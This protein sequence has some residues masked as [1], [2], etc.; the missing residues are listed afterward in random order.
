MSVLGATSPAGVRSSSGAG[1]SPGPV[2]P[3]GVITRRSAWTSTSRQWG[4]GGPLD[5]PASAHRVGRSAVH[6]GARAR[7]DVVEPSD[8]AVLEVVLVAAQHQPDAARSVQRHQL[9]DLLRH[10]LVVGPGAAGAGGGRTASATG[11][12]LRPRGPRSAKSPPARSGGSSSKQCPPSCSPQVVSTHTS[13]SRPPI[14]SSVEQ[15]RL[16][17]ASPPRDHVEPNR[18]LEVEVVGQLLPVVVGLLVRAVVV[19]GRRVHGQV[20]DEV[21]VRL[22][23]GEVPVVVLVAALLQSV[24]APAVDVVAQADDGADRV[25]WPPVRSIVRATPCWRAGLA[26]LIDARRRSRP[27]PGTSPG[28]VVVASTGGCASG[29]VAPAR[30]GRGSAALAVE[31]PLVGLPSAHAW[32]STATR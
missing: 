22:V 13:S 23:E 1:W 30:L 4:G 9:S 21:A 31:H 20:V 3:K 11:R 12:R 15:S 29:P 7:H 14:G 10:A 28:R 18:G 24:R 16:Q 5:V 32:P 19:A 6:L 17:D 27:T 25:A 8:P 2:A 26:V